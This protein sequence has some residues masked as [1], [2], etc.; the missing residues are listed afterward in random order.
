MWRS[1]CLG[2][3]TGQV[4]S[5]LA[6]MTPDA[7]ANSLFRPGRW[8]RDEGTDNLSS[9]PGIHMVGRANQFLLVVL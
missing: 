5:L 3:L 9:G 1:L 6:M 7:F 2:S 4:G 8:L